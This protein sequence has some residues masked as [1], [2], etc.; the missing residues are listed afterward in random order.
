LNAAGSLLGI[1]NYWPI[2]NYTYLDVSAQNLSP[3]GSVAVVNDRLGNANSAFQTPLNSYAQ[4]PS[5][6]YF[7]SGSFS[8]TMW[9][10]NQNSGNL[11]ALFDFGN[12][13]VD[14]VGF[15]SN[16]A[17]SGMACSPSTS[18]F[19]LTTTAYTLACSS[20]SFTNGV[21][22]HLALVSNMASLTSYIY[23]NVALVT[24]AGS[25]LAIRNLT[26]SSNY[27]GYSGFNINGY[28]LF[29]EIKL[30]GK[31]LTAQDVLND[32]NKNQTYLMY[33]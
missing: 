6:L 26:R 10:Q 19:Q 24:T 2:I 4:A 22:Y 13:N 8:V 7:T 11:K 32:F 29:D 23:V 31:V 28:W 27:F 17:A 30:H 16:V 14:N 21:W 9:I 18:Y 12:G 1:T 33:V 3:V 20:A 15:F 25:Q 5:G